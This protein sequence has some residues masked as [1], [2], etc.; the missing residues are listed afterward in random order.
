MWLK[1]TA[2]EDDLELLAIDKRV[3]QRGTGRSA[4][5]RGQY[6]DIT[7]NNM[8]TMATTSILKVRSAYHKE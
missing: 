4:A 1:M 5:A 8:T 6:G 2:Q 3:V 7:M